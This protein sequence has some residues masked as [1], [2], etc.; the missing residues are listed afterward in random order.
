MFIFMRGTAVRSSCIN[1]RQICDAYDRKMGIVRARARL[2]FTKSANICTRYAHQHFYLWYAVLATKYYTSRV[3][4]CVFVLGALSWCDGWKCV[5]F[6]DV[7][8]KRDKM[9]HT[10]TRSKYMHTRILT[11]FALWC[12][13]FKRFRNKFY[14]F[15]RARCMRRPLL[16]FVIKPNEMLNFKFEF[17]FIQPKQRVVKQA[18]AAPTTTKKYDF[19]I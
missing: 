10:H 12:E 9:P 1:T 19:K 4:V 16:Q 5:W 3:C 6:G 17:K 18:T 2:V 11:D 13:N 7:M 15:W 8:V 14:Y